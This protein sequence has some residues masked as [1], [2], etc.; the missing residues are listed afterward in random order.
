M[1]SAAKIYVAVKARFSPDGKLMPFSL[2]WEDGK[3]FEIDEDIDVRRAASLKSGGAGIRYTVRTSKA[4]E[5]TCFG[6]G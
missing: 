4:G 1:G 5:N 6:R 2:E 3:E